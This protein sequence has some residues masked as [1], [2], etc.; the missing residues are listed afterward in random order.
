MIITTIKNFIAFLFAPDY[1]WYTVAV[2]ILAIALAIG[3]G[4]AILR[5]YDEEG[6]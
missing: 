6:K 3:C 2:L 4:I 5:E 1:L